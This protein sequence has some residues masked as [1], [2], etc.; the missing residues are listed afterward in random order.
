MTFGQT[1]KQLI[2]ISGVKSAHLADA[3]GYDASYISRWANDIKLPSLKNNDDLFLKISDVVIACCDDVSLDELKLTYLSD[4]KFSNLQDAVSNALNT[5]Y[6]NSQAAATLNTTA[7]NAI[8]LAG[9]FAR[10]IS[11]LFN[12][13][14]IQCASEN[15]SDQV[16]CYTS[17]PLSLYSNKDSMFWEST[18]T[19]PDIQDKLF[20]VMHQ[21]INM[22][23]FA[24]NVDSYCAAICTYAYYGPSIRYEFYMDESE[25]DVYAVQFVVVEDHFLSQS[26][27]SSF[28]G[29][30]NQMICT[31]RGVILRYNI[32][33]KKKLRV[34]PKL[35]EYCS[36]RELSNNHFLYNYMIDGN[37]R[38]LLNVMHPIY[39][40]DTLVAT[41]MAEYAPGLPEDDFQ[42]F[43]NSLCADAKKEVVIFKSAILEYI[44]SGHIYLFGRLL[45]IRKEHRIE[46]LTQLLEII[47]RGDCNLTIL[48]DDNPLLCRSDM[49]LS[50]YLSKDAAFAIPRTDNDLAIKFRSK[51]TV[52]HFNCFFEH[53]QGMNRE[54]ILN[55][56]EAED[57]VRRG[58]MR[59]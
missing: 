30:H 43:Y 52:E 38:F 13:A 11:K 47:E 21:I 16:N 17:T 40:G 55:G 33:L 59:I 14:I 4:G 46:H 26:I 22:K 18:L 54:Y 19:D 41:A 27:T 34:C 20:I 39:M 10:D 28:S 6:A 36:I 31:D 51:R 57:F 5:A 42:I 53:L 29:F 12:A 48:N 56:K 8:C 44:Y 23:D 3:L 9:G 15:R 58:L 2:S 7:P 32:A 24:Q 49:R 37:I 25:S 1:L 35:L 50:V 45:T